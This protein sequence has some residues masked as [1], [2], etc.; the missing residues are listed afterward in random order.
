MTTF[1]DTITKTLL[2]NSNP[3]VWSISSSW[4][5]CSSDIDPT[6]VNRLSIGHGTVVIDGATGAVTIADGTTL[7][8]A[9]I[10]FWSSIQIL[11][12]SMV[13]K[14][15]DLEEQVYDLQSELEALLY[16]PDEDEDV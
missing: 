12:I 11:G 10:A 13:D 9:S 16:Q 15:M 7:D 6:S 3:Y 8:E 1:L 4:S 14:I 2:P 5:I